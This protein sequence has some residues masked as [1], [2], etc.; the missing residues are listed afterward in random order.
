MTTTIEELDAVRHALTQVYD[1]ELGLVDD[2]PAEL[3]ITAGPAVRTALSLTPPTVAAG[4][5]CAVTCVAQDQYGNVA[6]ANLRLEASPS[7]SVTIEGTT[8]ISATQAGTYDITCFAATVDEAARQHGSLTVNAGPQAGM[9]LRFLPEQLAYRLMQQVTVLGEAVDAYGNPIAG[10]LQVASIEAMPA[11]HHKVV[12]PNL[13]KI[14]FDL[15]GFYTVTA[16]AVSDPSLT[17][18]AELVVDETRPELTLTSPERGLVT[19]L[20]EQVTL[21]GTVSDNLGRIGE[22]RVGDLPIPIAPEGGAFSLQVALAYAVNLLDVHALDPYGNEAIATR[23]VEKSTEFHGLVARDFQQDGIDNGLVLVLLPEVF[24]DGDHTEANR[25]DLAHLMEFIIENLD[26]ASLLPNP[27]ATFGCIGGSCSLEFDSVTMQDVKVTLTLT[28][29]RIHFKGELEQLAGAVTLWFPCD[30]PVICAQRPL[31][32][33]PGTVSTQRV[34]IDS[35]IFLAIIGGETVAR[36][37]NTVVQIEPLEVSISDPT[38]VGQAAIDLVITLIQEPLVAALEGLVVGVIENELAKALGGLFGALTIDQEFPLASPVPG[39][40]PNILVVKTQPKGVDIAPERLQLRVDGLS[41][42]KFPARPHETL[43]AI[44]HRGCAPTTALTYP[45]PAPI[46]VGLHDDFINQLLFGVWEG[47]TLALHLGP[48]EAAGLVG[49][50]GLRDAHITVD[51]LLPPVF[52]SC[53]A[54]GTSVMERVQLGDLWLEAEASFA[55]EPIHLG[56]WILTEAPVT[57]AFAPNADGALQARLVLG[58]LDPMW[59]EVVINEGRF[60]ADDQAVVGLVQSQL[61]PRLLSTVADSATFTLPSIDL[62]ALT[63]AVPAGTI[64][65]LDVRQVG[66]DNAYLTVQGALE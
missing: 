27:L 11:G 10:D 36:T 26:I 20:L 43:G 52:D 7:D 46:V 63:S 42:A 25:D 4:Q 19:D 21:S 18:M 53:G 55:G 50:F 64:I 37:E 23:A 54:D 33:L 61:V 60:A 16:T 5:P 51:A 22:L 2:T 45:P 44:G 34:T 38:G 47:G 32:P 30:V 8:A 28:A 3:E 1:P 40:P 29:G 6:A 58:E 57:V 66:R 59:M 49:D 48:E 14:R 62:G 17:A 12:G 31:N 65:N 15:E 56:L 35:D 24:D 9:R 39:Q 13:E 41:Y